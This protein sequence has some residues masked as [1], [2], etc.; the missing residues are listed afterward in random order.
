[1]YGSGLAMIFKM[2]IMTDAAKR[3][4]VARWFT[5]ITS[6]PAWLETK[7]DWLVYMGHPAE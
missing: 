4:N 6:R 5:D 1:M 7:R 3:P 2:E